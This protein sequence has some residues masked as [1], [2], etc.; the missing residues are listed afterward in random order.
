[1]PKGKKVCFFTNSVKNLTTNSETT[2]ETVI[3]SSNV[4]ISCI[5]KQNLILI[6]FK[7]LIPAITGIA[8]KNANSLDVFLSAPT[9]IPPTTLAPEREVPGT[10]DKA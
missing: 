1:M 9:H 8:M 3:P 4:E 7:T 10:A 5:E 6:N 2:K